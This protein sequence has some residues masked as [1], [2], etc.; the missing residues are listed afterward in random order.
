M[1]WRIINVIWEVLTAVSVNITFFSDVTPCGLVET[2][3]RFRAT[4]WLHLHVMAVIKLCPKF[5]SDGSSETSVKN[6]ECVSYFGVMISN[7]V[8]FTREWFICKIYTYIYIYINIKR[9]ITKAATCFN[10]MCGTKQLTSKYIHIK[11]MRKCWKLK[12]EAT[13]PISGKRP[14]VEATD[15]S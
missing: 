11:E 8:R 6:V 13:D 9:Q 5:V 12:E 4:G 2:Y 1:W 15:L 7:Y 14:L 10:K 3:R